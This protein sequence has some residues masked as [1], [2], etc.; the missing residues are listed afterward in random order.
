MDLRIAVDTF[1]QRIISDIEATGALVDTPAFRAILTKDLELLLIRSAIVQ[2]RRSPE[3]WEA[4][5]MRTFGANWAE[6][7]VVESETDRAEK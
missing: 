5:L 6:L 7:D 4:M 3:E 1:T 2:G